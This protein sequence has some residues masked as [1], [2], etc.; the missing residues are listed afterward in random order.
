M[1]LEQL[2]NQRA[3]G[4]QTMIKTCK[5][6]SLVALTL[7]FICAP[8]AFAVTIVTHYIGGSAPE[9]AAGGGNLPDIMNAAARMWESAYSD[10]ITITLHYG[11]ATIGD[12]GTHTLIEQGEQPNH[13]IAGLILFDNSDAAPFFLDPTPNLNEEYKRRT[14]EFQDLGGGEINVA[15]VLAKP[16]GDAVGR[17]DLLS[18]ALHE[19]GH[20]MGLCA[21]NAS[22]IGQSY[23]G[24][25]RIDRELPFQGTIVPLAFNNSG[26]VPHF[27]SSVIAYGGVMGGINGNERRTLSELD[28]VANAQVSG[29]TIQ[30]LYPQPTIQSEQPETTDN[31]SK[32]GR[33]TSNSHASNRS[34]DRRRSLS[35]E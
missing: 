16:V 7:C 20:A 10:P 33:G 6:I 8:S 18:V 25:I 14:E 26:V 29:F 31:T 13:E 3:D 35:G 17:I 5:Q 34:S 28:I 24:V 1:K 21:A 9:N 23:D 15:R 27:D 2:L 4:V 11:W 32:S 30:S 12:A 22:F 19:I